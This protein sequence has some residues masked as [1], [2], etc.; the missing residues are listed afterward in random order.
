MF[1]IAPAPGR[2]RGEQ[3]VEPKI[4][5]LGPVS[6]DPT[7]QLFARDRNVEVLRACL[8]AQVGLEIARR[9]A[10]DGVEMHREGDR[11]GGLERNSAWRQP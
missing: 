10:H 3:A 7:D 6:V 4:E 2:R 9:A 8:S 5:A 1:H 11:D